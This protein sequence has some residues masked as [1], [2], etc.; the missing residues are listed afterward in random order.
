MDEEYARIVND[1]VE[2]APRLYAL[3]RED[4]IEII[5]QSRALHVGGHFELLSGQHS[6]KFFQFLRIASDVDLLARVTEEM[7]SWVRARRLSVD[8]VLGPTSV[9]GLLADE[10]ARSL[11]DK[12]S[13][14]RT[15][16]ARV[17]GD[18]G[19]IVEQLEVGFEIEEG[20]NVLV[21]NDL[22][23]T[24]TGIDTLRKIVEAKRG[25]LVGVGLFSVRPPDTA[26]KVQGICEEL[27][28]IARLKLAA[29]GRGQEH[30][31]LCRK[32]VRLIYSRRMT[33]VGPLPEE[34]VRAEPAHICRKKD[35]V[36]PL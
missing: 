32:G 8:V 5:V 29:W 14:P 26:E 35:I 15:V 27:H 21:V 16:Y 18:R 31:E 36:R 23:T 24:A 25:R 9:G 22:S 7:V 20:E 12:I 30:C 19:R 6:D 17:D 10:V 3:R 33:G 11:N 2:V 34:A 28:V 4:V 1:L 13:G